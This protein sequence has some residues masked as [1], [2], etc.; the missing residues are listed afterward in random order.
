MTAH[1]MAGDRERCLNAGMDDYLSKP[2]YKVELLA[3]IDRSPLRR[4]SD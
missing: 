1:A 2:L 3:L 4:S